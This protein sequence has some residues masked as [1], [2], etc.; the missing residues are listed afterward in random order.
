[1]LNNSTDPFL[2][3]FPRDVVSNTSQSSKFCISL[4]RDINYMGFLCL[5]VSFNASKDEVQ[6]RY[7]KRWTILLSCLCYKQWHP[8]VQFCC[9]TTNRIWFSGTR[10]AI[11]E[12]CWFLHSTPSS[13]WNLSPPTWC[14]FPL[15]SQDAWLTVW[16]FLSSWSV[17]P[18]LSLPS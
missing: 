3:K 17:L 4:A 14:W 9:F 10:L 7:R 8:P 16:H 6:W 13:C 15:R 12:S 1:M 2:P 5:H 11:A 18:M